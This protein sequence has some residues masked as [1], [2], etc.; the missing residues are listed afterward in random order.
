MFSLDLSQEKKLYV[1]GGLRQKVGTK[2]VWVEVATVGDPAGVFLR[3]LAAEVIDSV[4]MPMIPLVVLTLGVAVI[5]VRRSLGA[6]VLAGRRRQRGGSDTAPLR[7]FRN[8][9]GGRPSP[10]PSTGCSIRFVRHQRATPVHRQNPRAQDAAFRHRT[11]LG[12]MTIPGAPP[13]GGRARM[14]ETVDHRSHLPT[15]SSEAIKVAELDLGGSQPTWCLAWRIDPGQ[16]ASDQA[17][18]ASL[19]AS[20]VMHLP[21]ARPCAI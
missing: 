20:S 6:L 5:S 1:A 13:G 14:S 10:L 19:P 2:D 8:A 18:G 9:A 16:P 21:F 12:R 11:E 15:S 7:R 17:R 3:I 4:W